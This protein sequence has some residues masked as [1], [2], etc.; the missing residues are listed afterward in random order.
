MV[1][2]EAMEHMKPMCYIYIY[3]SII[4]NYIAIYPS[5]CLSIYLFWVLHICVYISSNITTN[6]YMPWMPWKPH[7]G[8]STSL[9]TYFHASV[10]K[11]TYHSLESLTPPVPIKNGDCP[12][13]VICSAKR[14]VSAVGAFPSILPF[15]L[16]LILTQLLLL[17][18]GRKKPFPSQ[19]DDD[20][21][22]VV[23]RPFFRMK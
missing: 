5:I 12:R 18:L 16:E 11:M 17:C 8:L 23:P 4:Y 10:K 2:F 19:I 1:G 6:I 22:L 21:F 9:S 7:I 15:E 13:K 20:A 3:I 14:I